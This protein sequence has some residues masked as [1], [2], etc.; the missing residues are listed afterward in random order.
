M[1]NG[2]TL[3]LRGPTPVWRGLHLRAVTDG[4]LPVQW[5]LLG[6]V[7]GPKWDDP[8]AKAAFEGWQRLRAAAPVAILQA[9]Y[10]IKQELPFPM[11]GLDSDNGGEFINN[12]LLRFCEASKITFTRSRPFRK[13]DSCYVEQKNYSIVRKAA[14]YYRYDNDHQLALLEELYRHLRLYTNY[15][16]PVMKLVSK[17]RTGSSVHKHYDLPQTPFDR[18]LLQP[19]V[20]DAIK[21]KLSEEFDGLNPAELKRS[22]ARIQQTLFLSHSPIPRLTPGSS[23]PPLSHPWR[24][25]TM[26]RSRSN[27]APNIDSDHE[28]SHPA[29]PP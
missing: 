15:F 14:G 27:N 23:A 6:A 13:N 20:S 7:G 25:S 11:L 1:Y 18:V 8:A 3:D 9:L 2:E 17:T 21:D 24:K 12:H 5:V 22:L 28:N 4:P 29:K 26:F 16:Q 19:H 10:R